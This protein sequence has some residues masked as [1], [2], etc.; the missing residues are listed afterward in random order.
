LIQDRESNALQAA[1]MGGLAFF[2]GF[3]EGILASLLNHQAS[4]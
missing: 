1:G 2:F 4:D 3:F